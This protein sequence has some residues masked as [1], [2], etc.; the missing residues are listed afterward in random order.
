MKL[1]LH[2][3]MSFRVSEL[4]VLLGFAGRNKSGRKH[5]LLTKALQLLK[6]GC[7]PAVQ[8]KIKELYR[9]RFP[10]KILTPSDLSMLHIQAGQLPSATA[11]TQGTVCHLPYDH[12]SAAAAAVPAA[13][14]PP[15][16]VLGPK[17]ETDVQHLSPPIHPVHPDVKMKRLPFYDV[18]D[19]LIKPT[20]LAST[21]SQRFEEAHFTFALTPQQVQQI[22]TSRDIL[23]GAKCD[24]TVQVQL[25]FCLCETSC[26]QEDY[27]PPNLFVKV[28]GKLCP[29]PGYLPP[30]K[31]GAEPKRPS[32]PVNITPLAR[33]SATVPNT[34]V[35]NWSSEFGRN[36]SLSVY[37][38]KQLTSVT[39]LQKLRA[40]GIRN[41][42]HSRALIKEKLTADP[43]SEIATTSLRVSLMCPLGK[44]RL[45]VPCRAITCTHLQCF[46]AA[47]YLQMNEK[48]PTWTCP[49]CDKKAPYDNLIIDGLFMEIL[50]SCTD[51]DEIQFMEDGSWCPMKPKKENQEVCQAAAF[52]GIE[53][54]SLYTVSSEGKNSSEGKKKV[55]VIDLTLDSSSDEEEPPAKKQCSVSSVALPTAA[56]PK[57]VLSIDH[58]PSSVLRSPPMAA[59]G[60]DYLSNLHI[61]DYH[62]SYQV[63]SELQGLDLFS[64]LQSENQHYSPSVITSLDE[65]DTLGH[66][67]QY[68]GAS[69]HFINMNPLAPVMAGSHSAVSPAGGRISSIV[70]TG[71]LRESHGHNG[72][73]SSNAAL[74]ACR[75]DIISLD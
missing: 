42:D 19:E 39:L 44:M 5:E 9:R 43:D 61:P 38:V 13:L 64:F 2:M 58:Q 27:F 59:L 54:S 17:H 55:E 23:P 12:S 71:A 53:A 65:Q 56:G 11:L 45:T 28:N 47:L 49:V 35:V 22:L 3:V 18:Y 68:R 62:P 66:F 8:M 46:D 67:F 21:N 1:P 31:N 16:P 50:N 63:P 32:R 51:C 60:S 36:Y 37:L 20:T 48:K 14:L 69:S 75:P 29:L 30:T 4:Q 33:L 72:T 26:P 57:G 74:P 52:S 41:P 10:R 73:M 24:Y 40:K 15:V 7:S 70:S 25:R 34:I 6:S